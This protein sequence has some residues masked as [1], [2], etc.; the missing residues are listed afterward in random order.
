VGL[1]SRELR[2]AARRIVAEE[3][4][5]RITKRLLRQR[6]LEAATTF[7]VTEEWINFKASGPSYLQQVEN[8]MGRY[9]RDSDLGSRPIGKITSAD[10]VSWCEG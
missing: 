2:D 7:G 1:K 4:I 3:F 9:V 6:K 5:L 10:I 8:F